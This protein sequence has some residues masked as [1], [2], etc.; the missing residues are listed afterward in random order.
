MRHQIRLNSRMSGPLSRSSQPAGPGSPT[1]V[2]GTVLAG[3]G[4]ARPAVPVRLSRAPASHD[5]VRLAAVPGRAA[6]A[7]MT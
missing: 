1:V 2:A 3:T 7:C 4:V 6:A 5:E